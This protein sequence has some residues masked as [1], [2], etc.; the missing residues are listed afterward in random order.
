MSKD[1]YVVAVTV[2]GKKARNLKIVQK[3]A[4]FMNHQNE[5]SNRIV[6]GV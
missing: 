5:F 1:T 3:K 6:R 4:K 2:F